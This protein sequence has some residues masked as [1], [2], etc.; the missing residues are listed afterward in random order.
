M[1][2][3]KPVGIIV[4]WNLLCPVLHRK[5]ALMAWERLVTAIS[6]DQVAFFDRTGLSQ[7]VIYDGIKALI[8]GGIIRPIEKGNL[9]TFYV[10]PKVIHPF[11]L[12]GPGYEDRIRA[13]EQ[14]IWSPG[15]LMNDTTP[16][17]GYPYKHG[18][19]ARED[20]PMRED[21]DRG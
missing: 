3:N 18:L 5:A 8:E 19:S 13:F 4:D 16:V 12:K 7:K 6:K 9:Q 17:E 11:W 15:Q 1:I 10:N 2:E 20:A 21:F 14:G